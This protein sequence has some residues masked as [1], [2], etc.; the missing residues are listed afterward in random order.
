[1]VYLALGLIVAIL[2]FGAGAVKGAINGA[3]LVIFAI[4]LIGGIAYL[5]SSWF[6]LNGG[7]VFVWI[8]IGIPSTLFAAVVIFGLY[9]LIRGIDPQ[10]GERRR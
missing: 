2:L 8:V 3:M 10:T 7:M 4:S 1:M 5:V 6:S 9:C